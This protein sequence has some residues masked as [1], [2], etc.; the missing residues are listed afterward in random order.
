LLYAP[1]RSSGRRDSLV[2]GASGLG[3]GGVGALPVERTLGAIRPNRL[4]LG[5]A[6]WCDRER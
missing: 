6:G 2:E 5:K 4:T 1:A 3:S